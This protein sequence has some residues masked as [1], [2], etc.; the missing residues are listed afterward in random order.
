MSRHIQNPVKHIGWS[1]LWKW[2]NPKV[3]DLT[4]EG[5]D[6]VYLPNS[7]RFMDDIKLPSRW[8]Y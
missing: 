7:N 4:P 5:F 6:L 8:W 2:A 1:Y 3:P